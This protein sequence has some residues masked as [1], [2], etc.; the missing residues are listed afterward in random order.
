MGMTVAVLSGFLVAL[1]APWLH[2]LGRRTSGWMLALLPVALAV[3]LGSH[4]AQVAAGETFRESHAWAPGLGVE[5]SFY[6]DG[7]SLL[8]AL[9]IS[10]IGALVFVYAGGYLAGHGHLG[11]FYVFLLM[12]MASML[13]V[14]LADN[15]FTLYVFWE[16]T[17]LTSFL[18]IGF[19]HEREE[20][21]KAAWQA[22]LVTSGGGLAM[23]AGLVLLGQIGGAMELSVLTSQGD[24]IR[25]HTLYLPILFLIL[26]G[27][28]TKSAQFPFH[29]WLPAAMEAPPP[30]SAYLHSATMVKA[31]VY[32]LA[33]L[34]PALGGTEAWWY[35]VTLIGVATMLCGAYLALCGTDLK[36]ILAYSTVSALGVLVMLLGMGTTAAIQAALVF[37]L[38]H[39]LYK[40]ALFLVAGAV[41]HETGARD[42]DRLGGL[43]RAMPLTAT[44]GI[45][46]AL[47]LAGIA[48][49]FGFIGKEML[50]EAALGTEARRFL[51]P[52]IV[53]A[54][55]VFVAVACIVTI[56]VFLGERRPTPRHPHEAPPS[57]WLGPLLMAGIGLAFGLF[58]SW[59]ASWGLS[60]AVSAVLGQRGPHEPLQLSL[61]HGLTPALA[62]SAGSVLLGLAVYVGWNGL[63]R[64]NRRLDFLRS[65]GPAWWYDVALSGL[66]RLASAQTRLLQ[67]GYLRY[68]ILACLGTTVAL[69]GYA[70]IAS[71]GLS[72]RFVGPEVR[73]YEAALAGLLLVA[74]LTAVRSRTRLAA[75]AALGVVGYGMA[76]AFI[77]FGAPDLAMT[78]FAIETLTVILFV[79]VLYR[80][81]RFAV[82]S[83]RWDRIRDAAVALT[84]GLLVTALVLTAIH[85]ATPPPVSRYYAE[86]S[87]SAA[88]GRNIVNV[89]LVDF[90][91]FDTLGEITVLA[92]AGIGVYALVKLRPSSSK[93]DET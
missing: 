43:W 32:L 79:L 69:T 54:G 89:I 49:F 28:F 38:A 13:G 92:V 85:A 17:S 1:A 58:S 83:S 29:F 84:T 74:A 24:A 47:S 31:G 42:A 48:P 70:L 10:G 86:H 39:A 91:G 50:L 25:Q 82:F 52:V 35:L 27:A 5:L 64:V 93:D 87:V 53:L 41:D 90:R 73:F 8:F 34:S 57:L 21:R 68:Y 88:H 11:R 33:R 45:L 77:L 65:H 20:A 72:W 16:L 2:R 7:L 19:E 30:V 67:S 18:L 3:Y 14:V 40:G 62:L 59:V 60:P 36:R 80:L 75:V 23:L 22:L 66:N 9:L 76:I 81:P 44:A 78:Q 46:A 4:I 51:V 56:R 26:V 6:L 71:V 15:L 55:A 12:F 63:R 61:W 37:L